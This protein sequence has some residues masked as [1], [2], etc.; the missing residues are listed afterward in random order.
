MYCNIVMQYESFRLLV[1]V[2]RVSQTRAHHPVQYYSA[3]PTSIALSTCAGNSGRR[4]FGLCDRTD[5]IEPLFAP[6]AS[7]RTSTYGRVQNVKLLGRTESGSTVANA[8][9]CTNSGVCATVAFMDI[10]SASKAHN[11]EHVL[12][13]RTLTTE[14]YEPAAIPSAAGAPSAGSSPA[15]SGYSGSSSSVNST[16]APSSV[17]RYHLS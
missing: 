14:Y 2:H 7:S 1:M 16:P 11:A 3:P 4:G 10:K 5:Q 12:D 17:S 6:P 15:G 13:E 8:S 9:S